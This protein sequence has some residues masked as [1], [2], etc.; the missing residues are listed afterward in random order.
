MSQTGAMVAPLN[1]ATVTAVL[2]PTNTGK[3]H[4]AVERMLGRSSGVIG[5]PLR[6]LAREIYDR[7]TAQKG[8]AQVALITGE[9]KIVPPSARYFICTVEAMPVDRRFAFLAVDEVQLMANHERGHIFTDRVL[10]ARGQEETLF[11]GAETVKP[12]LRTLVPKIR[13]E[14]RERFSTLHYDGAKK[15]T[16]LPKRS[17]IVAF[18]TAEVYALAE[19]IRRYRGG[20]AVVMGGLS[21]RTRNAQAEMFQNGEVDFLV[22]TDAVGMGLNLDTDHVAFAGLTKYDGRRRRYLT[23][24]EAGQIAGRAGRFRNDGTFGTTGDC[25]PMDDELVKRIE[26]HEFEPLDYAEWRNSN[27]D[28][29]SLKSLVDTLHAPRP[30]KRLRRIKGTEDEAVLERL[31][32][33]D[34]IS[35]RI[36]VPAQ[37]RQLWEICQIP[38]FR[39]LTIDA[40]VRLLQDIYRILVRGGGKLSTDF[41]TQRIDRLDD[42]SGGVHELSS[43]LASIR[44]WAYCASKTNWMPKKNLNYGKTLANHA[45]EVE[46]RLSDALHASLIARFVDKRTSKLL[47]GIGAD[48]YMSATIKDNGDVFVDDHLIGQLEGLTFKPDVSGSGLEAKALDAAAAKAVGPEIDRRLT[49]LCGGAHNIFTLSDRG[50]ILWGGMVVGR[51]APSGSVFTPDAEVIASDFANSNLRNLASDRMRDFLRAEVAAHLG[52]L[53]GLREMKDREDVLPEA[54]GFAYTLLESNGSVERRDHLKTIQNLNQ[55]ARRQLRELGVQF[56]FYNV[57]MPDMLKPKP[58]RLLSLL[59][60]YGAG[61][62]KN[63]FIPFAGVTSIPNEGDLSSENFSERALAHAGYRA[64]GTRIVRLDI[65]NRLSLMIRQAQDQFGKIPGTDTRGRP[66]QIMQE[67][68]SLLGG[69]YEDTQKVLTALGYQSETRE[70]LPDLSKPEESS[71]EK[72]ADTPKT[73]E[74]TKSEAGP[75]K[76]SSPEENTPETVS[77]KPKSA[78]TSKPKKTSGRNDLNLYN[79]RVQSDDG[80]VT[81]IAN[82]EVWLIPSRGQ[83]GFKPKGGPS[84]NKKPRHKGGKG[85]PK[86]VYTSGRSGGSAPK[87]KASIK[88]SPFAALAALNIDESSKNGKK[89][90]K[91]SDT[92]KKPDSDKESKKS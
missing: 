73:E 64:V 91:V 58:A 90:K 14:H 36:K 41:M 33:I 34:E 28:F 63:P 50:E 66:F 74:K 61:G 40:H 21:P 56:G 89:D 86:A 69:T 20:A 31:M 38:D 8:K 15:L 49:S 77:E 6:L 67:M 75:E 24:M 72:A 68:L 13:F 82:K 12:V 57:Y 43:R 3:T 88:N 81:E 87:G 18:S 27:L 44:T 22:A 71:S 51:I 19:L 45:R 48:A 11:L 83:K 7:V 9:E 53:K 59:N 23:P 5:L 1:P 2:G 4:Y 46:D 76:T 65:L 62:D 92:E 79:N 60:A 25:Q 29:S 16:R 42:T 84:Q 39:N 55:D 85:K 30:T 70:S 35:Q 37:V 32:A 26:N 47:K 10:N 54:K 17:V 78:G 80:S 52:P